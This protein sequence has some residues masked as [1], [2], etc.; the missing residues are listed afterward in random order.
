[1]TIR[2]FAGLAVLTLSTLPLL[3]SSVAAQ[4][5]EDAP[6]N[7]CIEVYWAGWELG[8]LQSVAGHP[9]S[10]YAQAAGRHMRRLSATLEAANQLCCQFCETWPDWLEIRSG[11]EATA[12]ELL[13]APRGAATAERQALLTWAESRSDRLLEGLNRCDLAEE[14]PCK[15][16]GVVECA[17]TYFK[18]GVYLGRAARSLSAAGEGVATGQGARQDSLESLGSAGDLIAALRADGG[19]GA[20]GQT[21]RCDY[22]WEAEIGAG[23]LLSEALEEPQA[24]SDARLAVTATEAHR[25]VLRTLLDGRPDLGVSPCPIGAAHSHAECEFAEEHGHSMPADQGD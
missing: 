12:E 25:I 1:M 15:W 14:S 19:P 23:R 5:V 18:L 22:L 20:T 17:R 2:H 6:T 9:I 13:D 11:I 7:C 8:Q 3:P 21:L 4:T 24:H 16:L 10:D